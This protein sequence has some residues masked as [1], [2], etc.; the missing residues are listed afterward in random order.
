MRIKVW[1][2]LW[3]CSART[4]AVQHRSL[5]TLLW[6]RFVVSRECYAGKLVVLEMLLRCRIIGLRCSISMPTRNYYT[7]YKKQGSNNLNV[8]HFQI[9]VLENFSICSKFSNLYFDIGQTN[10]WWGEY[11]QNYQLK[12]DTLKIIVPTLVVRV[13]IW[14]GVQEVKNTITWL[15]EKLNKTIWKTFSTL[16]ILLVS[17]LTKVSKDFFLYSLQVTGFIT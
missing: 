8:F 12:F 10:L 14:D 6:P 4:R 13:R 5:L 16:K 1:N 3:L 11:Q 17:F 2:S 7:Q 9:W 15:L